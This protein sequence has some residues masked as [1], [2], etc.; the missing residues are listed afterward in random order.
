MLLPASLAEIRRAGRNSTMAI[1][2]F[3]TPADWR[4]GSACSGRGAST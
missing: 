4:C 3:A 2:E 1:G